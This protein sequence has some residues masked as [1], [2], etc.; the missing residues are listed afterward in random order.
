MFCSVAAIILN[1]SA[2]GINAVLSTSSASAP[3]FNPP[4]A[5]SSRVV[6]NTVS[7]LKFAMVC[8]SLD[9]PLSDVFFSEGIL[10]CG[11]SHLAASA[12]SANNLQ[13]FV[14]SFLLGIFFFA[15]VSSVEKKNKQM[16]MRVVRERYGGGK[17]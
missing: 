10:K 2:S 4:S 14:V 3:S 7:V 9:L 6:C 12:A 13:N 16:E 11:S 15:V 5:A 17:N 1:V 8:S